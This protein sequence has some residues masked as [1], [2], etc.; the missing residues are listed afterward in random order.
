MSIGVQSCYDRRLGMNKEVV[1]ECNKCSSC[2]KVKTCLKTGWCPEVWD[3]ILCWPSTAP[4]DLSILPC[5]SYIA[6]FDTE[7]IIINIKV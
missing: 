5:P 4:G 2:L 3:E 7:V 6:G 1:N